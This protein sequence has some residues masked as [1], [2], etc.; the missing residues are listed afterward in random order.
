MGRTGS[1]GASA[2]SPCTDGRLLVV[3][4][5]PADVSDSAGARTVPSAI[6]K[7]WP[8]RK[9][10]LS[11]A[12]YGRTKLMD[13]VAPLGFFAGIVRRSRQGDGLE[14]AP[15]RRVVDRAFGRMIRWRRPVRDYEKRLDA[16]KAMIHAA[17]GALLLRRVAHRRVP[18]G[19]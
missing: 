13:K 15:G 17:T 7:R 18:K 9:H 14:V 19:I 10:L 6:R 1:P 16:S 5:S 8:W 2:T 11:D 4:L 12:R 3:N